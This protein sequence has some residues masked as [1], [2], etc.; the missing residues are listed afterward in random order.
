MDH[1]KSKVD[2]Y[3]QKYTKFPVTCLTRMTTLHRA[4]SPERKVQN[5]KKNSDGSK[6]KLT[7]VTKLSEK[8]W[9]KFVRTGPLHFLGG[10]LS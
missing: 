2:R 3:A 9:Y 6:K 10:P 7:I 4:Q 5:E 1:L 8:S